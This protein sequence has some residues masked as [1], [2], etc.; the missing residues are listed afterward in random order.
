MIY[1]G[2]DANCASCFAIGDAALSSC[3][4]CNVGYNLA[5]NNTCVTAISCWDVK[6]L[7]QASVSGLYYIK[8][9]AASSSIL[10]Y[11][12]FVA[13]FNEA[14][15]IGVSLLENACLTWKKLKAICHLV[16]KTSYRFF[17]M[18]IDDGGW[19][20]CYSTNGIVSE[21]Y[22]QTDYL[23]SPAIYLLW[24]TGL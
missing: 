2:K 16:T 23:T 4:G 18:T 11:C 12:E 19:Q 5:S 14:Y 20:M 21:Q 17:R 13:R 8:P 10:A 3:L 9:P 22:F 6:A 24:L 15:F 1:L 7:N